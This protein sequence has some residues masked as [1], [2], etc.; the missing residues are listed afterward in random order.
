MRFPKMTAMLLALASFVATVPRAGG[1]GLPNLGEAAQ[2]VFT[3]QQ[4]RR[5]GEAIMQ[6]IRRDRQYLDDPELTDYLNGLGYRLVAV[7]PDNAQ[8]FEFFVVRDPLLNAFALPGGFIGVHTGLILAAQNESELAGVLAHEI[9]HVTQKHLARILAK[10][11]Q[12]LLTS[13]AALAVAILAARSNPQVSNAAIMASQAAQI[14]TQ[15]DFT[16]EHEREADR[17]GVLILQ[18]AGYDPHGM[19]QFFER[20]QRASRYYENNAPEYLRTHPV[21]TER[22]ADVQNRVAA[23][24]YKQVPDSL[25]FQLLRAKLRSTEGD[26]RRSVQEFEAALKERKYA[27]EAAQRY[28]LTHALLRLKDWGRAEK[29]LAQLRR[30][31]PA[32]PMVEALGGRIMR[33]T[34]RYDA[35]AGLYAKALKSHPGHRE[36]VYGYLDALLKNRRHDEALKYVNERLRLY[37]GDHRLYL[38]QAEGYARAGKGL[39]QHQAL[40]EAAVLQGNYVGAIEQL[41]I[42]LKSGDGD[43]YQLSMAEARLRELRRLDSERKAEAKKRQQLR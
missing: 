20:L 10:D 3:P 31:L 34:G 13:V 12:G 25:E 5:V 37:P 39:A 36:L 8:D 1:D 19:A 9:A 30:L 32:H 27:S 35:A 18:Q 38:L 15:L 21:T 33:E 42:A 29:E 6:E 4:E 22:I 2:S 26:A 24:P 14:Q 17:V 16:R 43:F 41:E 23:I 40:A 28:G 11:Q 7:S